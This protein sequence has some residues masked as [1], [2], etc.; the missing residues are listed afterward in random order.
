MNTDPFVEPKTPILLGNVSDGWQAT[1]TVLMP[2][3]STIDIIMT[4]S[5]DSIDTVS[6]PYQFC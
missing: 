5:K 3:N 4:I 1:T 2:F 6:H